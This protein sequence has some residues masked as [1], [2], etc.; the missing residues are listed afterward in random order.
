MKYMKYIYTVIPYTSTGDI[1]IEYV[2][3]FTDED[4]AKHYATTSSFFDYTI[5]ENLLT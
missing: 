2:N 5:I 1:V 4:K 3:S